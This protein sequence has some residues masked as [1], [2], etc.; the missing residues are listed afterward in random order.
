VVADDHPSFVEAVS[1]LLTD[2]A[3]D[4]VGHAFDG[5]TALAVI[6]KWKPTVA[7]L[8][9]TMP[10]MDGI[11]V[12]RRARLMVAETASVLYTGFGDRQLLVA[13]LDVGA[14]GFV[15]KEGP[16]DGLVRAVTLA[17]RGETYVDPA[18]AGTLL[19]AATAELPELSKREREALRHLAD[20]KGNEEIAQ[21]L[22]ISSATVR[23]YISRAMEK[24]EADTR[25]QAVATALRQSLI[26]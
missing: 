5:P 13:A 6:A 23:T 2:H 16:M 3:I 19:H 11:E 8:D 10:R 26:A 22:G 7:V 15:L 1:R 20:G 17:A 4:V 14:R 12:A 24:L 25:T 9:V 18:L 21:A